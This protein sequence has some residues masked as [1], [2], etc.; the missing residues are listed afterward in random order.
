M[1]KLDEK[2]QP[3][4]ETLANR[5]PIITSVFCW[6][7]TLRI[8]ILSAEMIDKTNDSVLICAATPTETPKE[9]PISIRKI[10][11]RIPGGYNAKFDTNS[12][13]KKKP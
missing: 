5:R 13:D 3:I 12:D 2:P 6:Y 8:P 7:L 4:A 9:A 11:V 10:P 1:V